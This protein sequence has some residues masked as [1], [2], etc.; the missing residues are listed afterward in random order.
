MFIPS[1]LEE[2]EAV[3]R[4]TGQSLNSP[5]GELSL[6][7]N[8]PL[9]Y[10]YHIN[11]WCDQL[12]SVGSSVGDALICVVAAILSVVTAG[13]NLLVVISY[14]MDRRLR[15]VTNYFFLQFFDTVGWVI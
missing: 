6:S 7:L 10:Y 13:G 11:G 12:L 1:L 8:Y 2:L 9:A 3:L 15:T 14:R 4:L 5:G